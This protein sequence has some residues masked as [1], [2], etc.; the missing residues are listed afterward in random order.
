M[1]RPSVEFEKISFP[2]ILFSSEVLIDIPK[3]ILSCTRLSEKLKLL[4][5]TSTPPGELL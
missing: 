2:A 1:T 3:P 5:T 4:E